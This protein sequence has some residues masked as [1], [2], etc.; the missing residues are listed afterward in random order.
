MSVVKGLDSIIEEMLGGSDRASALVGAAVVEHYLQA[1]L[2]ARFAVK[3]RKFLD[4][5]LYSHS[6]P[7]GT[8][9]AKIA[10][11]YAMGLIGPV[12]FRD[13]NLVRRIRND[14]AHEPNP[15]SFDESSISSRCSEISWIASW[16]KDGVQLGNRKTEFVHAVAA[17]S[18][19]LIQEADSPTSIAPAPA[20]A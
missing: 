12:M 7:F 1:A 18:G 14:F 11:A 13:L 8:F 9:S 20:I 15:V 10:G 16:R 3:N 19:L 2:T 5:S 4:E 6:G 17:M